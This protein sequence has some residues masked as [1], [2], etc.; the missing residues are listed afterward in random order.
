MPLKKGLSV[1]IYGSEEEYNEQCQTTCFMTL[2]FYLSFGTKRHCFGQNA[3]FYL[4]KTMSF[5]CFWL[6]LGYKSPILISAFNLTI[7][8]IRFLIEFNIKNQF[9]FT[10]KKFKKKTLDLS[11]FF[12]LVLGLG[13]FQFYPQFTFQLLISSISPLFTTKF[14]S[15]IYTP[16]TKRSLFLNFFNLTP[17]W[18]P[19]FNF[20]AI[21]SLISPNSTWKKLNL[22]L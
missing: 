18:P 7:F 19:N 14:G 20:L 4:N 22:V 21:L 17:N 16:F 9:N 3:T 6:K 2:F 12:N 15:L 1:I 8:S 13:Y 5:W 11:V 10:P